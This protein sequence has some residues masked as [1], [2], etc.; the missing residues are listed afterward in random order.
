[1]HTY[2]LHEHEI[3]TKLYPIASSTD[4]NLYV[5]IY[6]Y[7]GIR[8]PE[9]VEEGGIIMASYSYNL[10][11]H[12]CH[13]VTS[14]MRRSAPRPIQLPVAWPNSSSPPSHQRQPPDS[15]EFSVGNGFLQNFSKQEQVLQVQWYKHVS[16]MENHTKISD[17]G[18]NK[19]FVWLKHL[20]WEH[21]MVRTKQNHPKHLT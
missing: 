11:K 6:M 14:K 4:L 5:Y 7:I 15:A 3:F 9:H 21:A 17:T 18:D 10:L 19:Q 2:T 12:H 1:M 13:P 20:S 16:F 8:L